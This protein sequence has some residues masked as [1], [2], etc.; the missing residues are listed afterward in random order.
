MPVPSIHGIF[1]YIWLIFMVN[2]GKYTYTMHGC[3][4]EGLKRASCEAL[5]RF[6]CVGCPWRGAPWH[7]ASSSYRIGSSAKTLQELRGLWG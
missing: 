5:T 2:K 6:A 4:A 1:T 3:Y 7:G